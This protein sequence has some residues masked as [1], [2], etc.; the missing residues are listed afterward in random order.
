MENVQRDVAHVIGEDKPMTDRESTTAE[1]EKRA[2][3]EPAENAAGPELGDTVEALGGKADVKAQM[4]AR[5]EERTAGLR[6]RREVLR[7]RQE[8]LKAKVADARGRASEATPEDAKRAASR[9][10]QTAAE[11]PMPAIGIAFGAGLL[12]GRLIRRRY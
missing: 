5:V 9:V 10:A 3:P 8:D 12:L 1:T 11:R 2:G 6:A 7:Q 4:R